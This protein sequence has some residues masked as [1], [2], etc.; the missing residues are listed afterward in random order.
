M[1]IEKKDPK[2]IK[3]ELVKIVKSKTVFDQKINQLAFLIT[4]NQ[5]QTK[6]ILKQGFVG[7][8]L[9]NKELWKQNQELKEQ[10]KILGDEVQFLIREA[11]SLPY[12]N[13]FRGAR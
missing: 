9:Q 2:N 12:S 8:A 7:I 3:P 6:S 1:T 13:S 10:L 11:E 4:E 5:S